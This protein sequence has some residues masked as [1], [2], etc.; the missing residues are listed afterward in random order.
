[1]FYDDIN[2]LI[3]REKLEAKYVEIIKVHNPLL[4]EILT[5]DGWSKL[6][7]GFVPKDYSKSEKKVLIIGRET[8]DWLKK[9]IAFSSYG[10]AEVKFLMEKSRQ[11]VVCEYKK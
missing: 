3:L 2:D 8:K 10:S 5:Q 4:K 6:H 1:M 11:C 7:L 9:G